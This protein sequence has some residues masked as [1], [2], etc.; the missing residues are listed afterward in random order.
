MP[1]WCEQEVYIHGETSMVTHLYWELKER[2]RFC[3]VVCPIPLEVIGQP[4][5]G[6]GTSPQWDWRCNKW[7]TKW[8]V[9]DILIKEEL[10]NGDDHYPIPTSYFRFVCKTAW[11]AP[12]PVWEKLHRLGIEVQAEYEV[13][14]TDVVGEFTLG[15]HH[16]RT[17]TDEEIKEREKK[18]M[19][20][21]L[22]I[23]P[24]TNGVGVWEVTSDYGGAEV[25][26]SREEAEKRLKE[27]QD[28]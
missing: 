4:F 23:V 9:Q 13:E 12:I 15:E 20:D 2:K 16:C 17:L 5:D 22:E 19:K 3:D 1:N 26:D 10:V 6:K 14:G 11:D 25:F 21:S 8:E 7:N 24:C 28:A 27:L 18:W